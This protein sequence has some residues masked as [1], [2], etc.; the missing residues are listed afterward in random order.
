VSVETA[1][2]LQ[3]LRP[4]RAKTFVTKWN[5][6]HHLLICFY[7]KN[8]KTDKLTNSTYYIKYN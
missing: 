4:A 2:T 6:C 5:K 1:S 8:T 3:S 7:K